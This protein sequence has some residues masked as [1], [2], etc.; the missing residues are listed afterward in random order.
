MSFVTVTLK[1]KFGKKIDSFVARRGTSLWYNIRKRG[2]SI[3]ASCSGV[4]V[5]CKCDIYVEATSFTENI[6]PTQAFEV[7]VL[8]SNALEKIGVNLPAGIINPEKTKRI[9]CLMRLLT[10]TT[11]SADYW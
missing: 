11:V 10:D 3:G 6:Q 7:S 9:S 2:V 8:E 4:G 5:C 1:N